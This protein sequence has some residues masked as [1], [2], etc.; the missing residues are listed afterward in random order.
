[1]SRYIAHSARADLIADAM[2]TRQQQQTKRIVAAYRAAYR[3]SLWYHIKV[4]LAA[5]F[6]R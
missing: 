5:L 1:M 6:G 3:S 2:A 4:E